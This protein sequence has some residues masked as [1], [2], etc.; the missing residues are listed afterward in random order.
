MRSVYS[1]LPN[2]FWGGYLADARLPTPPH[3]SLGS[4]C[5]RRAAHENL[6]LLA[7]ERHRLAPRHGSIQRGKIVLQCD[8]DTAGR[9]VEHRDAVQVHCDVR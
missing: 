9:V 7:H 3:M 1:P 8:G 2:R 6:R 4:E 5:S